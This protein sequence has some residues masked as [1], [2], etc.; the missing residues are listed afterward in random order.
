MEPF[1]GLAATEIEARAFLKSVP[2]VQ[3]GRRRFTADEIAVPERLNFSAQPTMSTQQGFGLV[4]HDI[5]KLDTPFAERIVTTSPDVTVST[6]LGAWVNRRGLFSKE[7]TADLF[8]TERI[9]STYNWA[10]STVGQHVELGIAEM[11]LFI[12]L[13]AL[14]LS[15]SIFGERILR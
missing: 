10:L 15:H 11:N 9:P 4:M 8:R 12:M 5:S 1:E 13:S 7:P 14:G 2:F 6:N 3:R